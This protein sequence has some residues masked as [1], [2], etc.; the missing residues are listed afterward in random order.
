MEQS[1]PLIPVSGSARALWGDDAEKLSSMFYTYI[2]YSPGGNKKY[3]G[4]TSDLVNRL[5]VHNSG[6]VKS[7]KPYRPWEIF[8]YEAYRSK[9][10]A[11]K[12][13]LFYKSSQ[14]RRQLKKKFDLNDF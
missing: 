6:N 9:E 10:L 11:R 13:E 1:C 2:L 7:T 4:S 8:Y 14:G 5:K 12:T 3:I